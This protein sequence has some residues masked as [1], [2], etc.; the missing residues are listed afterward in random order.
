M[1]F[2]K[3]TFSDLSAVVTIYDELHQ[4]EEAGL[5]TTGWIRGIYPTEQTAVSAL[6]RDDLFV[7]EDAGQI[8]ASAVINQIQVDVYAGAPWEY[9]VPDEQVCV[10]HTLTV[11]PKAARQGLGSAFVRFYEEYA[12]EHGCPE[13]RIDTNERNKT[14]RSMYKKLGY[15]EIQIVPTV[16][17]GIPSV[18]LVLLEKHCHAP[19]L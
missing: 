19:L 12:A 8:H 2:R 1:T 15:Q 6:H 9:H 14:A 17:N 16:F 3:A 11:S 7:L 4:A 10:L 13:L 5:I 18:D